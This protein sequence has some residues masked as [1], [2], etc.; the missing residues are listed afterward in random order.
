MPKDT[1]KGGRSLEDDME[2]CT[3]RLR[4]GDQVWCIRTRRG[5]LVVTFLASKL[6]RWHAMDGQPLEEFTATPMHL[7]NGKA[8]FGK[9]GPWP[10]AEGN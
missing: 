9:E 6:E 7:V 1:K 4:E 8:L 3:K 5:G 2:W 10:R